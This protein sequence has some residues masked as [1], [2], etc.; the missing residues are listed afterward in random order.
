[1]RSYNQFCALARALDLVGERWTMLLLRE[2]LFGPRR[3][4][5]LLEGLPGIGPNL[6][7]ARLRR[8]QDEGL[9]TQ[10]TLPAPAGSRV[11]TL[12]ERGRGL[13]DALVALARWGMDPIEPPAPDDHRRPAWY[14]LA[15]RAAFRPGRARRDEEYELRVDGE[16][17][18]LRVRDGRAEASQGPGRNPALTLTLGLDDFLAVMTGRRAP[19]PGELSEQRGAFKRFLSAFALP[20]P[21]SPPARP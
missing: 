18:H 5:D 13:E 2:L 3:F 16:T 7:S 6:L 12:T 19:A 10:K 17:F 14:A 20:D 21:A 11:Y 4:G 8:L 9:V 1:M 15:L